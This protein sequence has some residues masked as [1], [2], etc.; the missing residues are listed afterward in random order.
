VLIQSMSFFL[1][2]YQKIFQQRFNASRVLPLGHHAVTGP[3]RPA[4]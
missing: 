3:L 4:V 2:T 1:G